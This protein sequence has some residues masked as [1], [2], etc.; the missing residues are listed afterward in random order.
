MT[1]AQNLSDHN[2]MTPFCAII[3]MVFISDTLF[4]RGVTP[5]VPVENS[6]LETLNSEDLQIQ[7]N[8]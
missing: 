1:A 3:G 6:S 8:G 7:R 2:K 4:I 5:K